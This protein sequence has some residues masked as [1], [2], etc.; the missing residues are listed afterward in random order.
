M[1]PSRGPAARSRP[2]PG[3]ARRAA[4]A[5]TRSATASAA[6][7][8]P[9]ARAAADIAAWATG[10]SSRRGRVEQRVGVE[11]LVLDQPGRAGLDQAGGIRPLVAG[12]VRIRARRPSAGP[13]AVTSA[14]VDE[15]GPADDQVRGDQG[16]QHLV[17]QERVRPVAARGRPRAGLSP[18]ERRRVAVLAG[19]VDDRHPLDESRQ[20]LGDRGVEAAD[21]LRPAEDEQD[22]LAR[23]RR[24]SAPRAASRSM[25][26]D[27]AD[28]RPGH[29]AR[30]AGGRRR[31]RSAGRLER[32]GERVGQPGRRPDRPTGDDVAVPHDDRDPQR[33]GGQQDRH[34]DVPAGREDR[35]RTVGGED[36]GRLRDRRRRGGSG[37]GRRGRPPRSSAA[38]ARRGAGGGC[39]PP[40]RGSPRGR[41]GR[42]AS[43]GRGPSGVARSD[44][45]TA[46]AG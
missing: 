4:A 39:P 18:G 14:S 28:R 22:P 24:P 13:S 43:A 20:R 30:P 32:D 15:P 45:A 27:V 37:R 12:G 21:G 34:G 46:S 7:G 42:P 31:Q 23:R 19:D 10:S 29:V 5:R 8:R 2:G 11:R 16:G 38:S 25:A 40:G 26:R 35:G 33:R 1:R 9:S 41:D 6:T 36:G 17:A 44:R 3:T